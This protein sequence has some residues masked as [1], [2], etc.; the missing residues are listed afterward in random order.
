MK[1]TKFEDKMPIL[2][3]NIL[4]VHENGGLICIT[5]FDLPLRAAI[6]ASCDSKRIQEFFYSDDANEEINTDITKED[7]WIYPSQ[8]KKPKKANR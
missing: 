5:E 7:F 8:I 2:G 6:L 1:F 4:V 3:A